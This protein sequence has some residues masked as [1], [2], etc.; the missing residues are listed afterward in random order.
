MNDTYGIGCIAI[1]FQLN[2]SL[3]FAYLCFLDI[4]A[5]LPAIAGRIFIF[6]LI[7]DACYKSNF[8]YADCNVTGWGFD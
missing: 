5:I 1:E 4:V 6:L 3:L 7:Y 8:H 2:C